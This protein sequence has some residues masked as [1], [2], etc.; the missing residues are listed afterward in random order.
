MKI[1]IFHHPGGIFTVFVLISP[2]SLITGLSNDVR[3][4]CPR[5][6]R[7]VKPTLGRWACEK[8]LVPTSTLWITPADQQKRERPWKLDCPTA[9]AAAAAATEG[10]RLCMQLPG[11][12][13]PSGGGSGGGGS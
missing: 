13:D 12:L 10:A 7:P 3:S 4:P 11:R 2:P 6:A 1:R 8:P 5:R 9:A